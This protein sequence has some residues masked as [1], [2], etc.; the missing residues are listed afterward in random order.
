[1]KIMI[2]GGAG[3]LGS[4][5]ANSALTLGFDITIIDNLTRVGSE[6][7][8]DWLRRN[9]D[10]RFQNIDIRDA[11]AIN[12]EIKSSQ[13]DYIFHLAGQVAMTTSLENPRL[14]FEVNVLGTLNILE[15]V[16]KYSENSII[17][18][19]S[20]NKIYGKLDQFEYTETK[21]RYT[22]DEF[23]KGFDE[24][25]PLAFSSPYGCSKGA[26]DQYVL[27]YCEMY[28]LKTIVFRHSS[29][30]GGRQFATSDQG[31]IG[32]FCKQALLTV[33]NPRHTFTISGNGKQ[34]RDILHI[35][36]MIELYLRMID[37]EI[38]YG[39]NDFNI[40]GSM[41]NSYSLLEL[42]QLLEDKL[43]VKLNY[44]TN[45]ARKSDQK[46]FVADISKIQNFCGWVPVSNID[47]KVEEM[48]EW[49]KVTMTQSM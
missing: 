38:H 34:V 8:L 37:T 47:R 5:L 45:E 6:T 13:P 28:N 40:G 27:D 7:N 35:D 10:F 18:Y 14:D 4:N 29:M 1:M 24:H 17:I 30:F 49:T 15:A 9:H 2:T 36:D 46:V 3:F 16:R 32:W 42:F 12:K 25:T 26:A 33:A 41:K 48:L 43:N 20:T 39:R 19:S 44:K 11:E 31:W 23:P 22:C 21:L